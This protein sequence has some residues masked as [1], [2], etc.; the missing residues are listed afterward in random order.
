MSRPPAMT[1]TRPTRSHT[2]LLEPVRGRVVGAVT[3]GAPGQVNVAITVIG[4]PSA[5]VPVA[6]TFW[7]PVR[8]S[9][10]AASIVASPA[11]SATPVPSTVP[12]RDTVT[13]LPGAAPVTVNV[14]S[15]PGEQPPSPAVS[16]FG[17][18]YC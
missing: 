4:S 2:M 5:L 6:P 3:P 12:P 10:H 11:A 15:P 9:G 13:V 14:T 17:R 18:A 7:R 8:P 1:R 16:V